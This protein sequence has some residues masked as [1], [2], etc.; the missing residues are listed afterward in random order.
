M[1]ERYSYRPS[2]V[3]RWL[4][5]I[6]WLFFGFFL[7]YVVIAD[8]MDLYTVDD[9]MQSMLGLSSGGSGGNGEREIL[10]YRN[11]MNPTIS[12]PVP[13]KD[14]MGMDYIPV[15]ADEATGDDGGSGGGKG[16]ILFYRN[17]MNPLVTSPAPAKD[18]MGMDYIPVYADEATND[19]GSA[20]TVKIDPAVVQEMNVQTV[21]VELRDLTHEIRTVGY[22]EYDQQRMVTVTTKYSGWVEKVYVNYVGEPVKKGQPL[23]EIYSPELLQTEQELLSAIN[24]AR[25]FDG[26]D[27]YA[28][29]RATSLLE[30][31]RA[32]L[33]YWDISPQ[34]IAELEQSGKT[35]RTLV[36]TAPS[37]GL[38]MKRMPGLEGMAVKPGMETFHIADISALWLSVEV[39]EEQV[40]FIQK[41]TPAQITLT[42][43][44]GETFRG[45]VRFIAPEFSEKTRTLPVKIEV[46]N[47]GGRLRAGMFAT[48]V[49]DPTA[50]AATI[51]VPSLAI[52]RSGQRN[53]I[54]V[55]K[56]DGRF[57]PRQVVLG[58]ESDGYVQILDG[59]EEGETIVT[60]SQFLIDSEASLQEAMQKMMDQRDGG[61]DAQ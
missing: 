35:F 8:P 46:P 30:A 20:T 17:P 32:R 52:L 40:A 48:V 1:N 28:Q 42:Y 54:M 24:Y 26:G 6:A 11:P 37:N 10:F 7:F 23:F 12:S 45:K 43:F 34:Q 2:A 51:A 22:L 29:S 53:M 60:S 14:E 49:F 38:V 47:P 41:N 33:A 59:I 61:D 25:K 16:E 50:V 15:Y 3:K 58:H 13:A 5:R 9:T 39:F 4:G 55:A 36:V 27:E 57:E 19:A 18:E 44:P 21:K 31:A 56:G